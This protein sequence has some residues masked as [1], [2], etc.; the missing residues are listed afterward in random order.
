MT[1]T[2][3]APVP[4]IACVIVS[5]NGAAWIAQCLQSLRDSRDVALQLIVVDNASADETVA[6]VRACADVEMIATGSN[7]GFG[8]ANNLGIARALQLGAELVFILNQD[9]H[10][11]P[12]ALAKLCEQAAAQPD[13]GIVCP[14]QLDAQGQEMDP[15]F[16]R[17]YL[18]PFAPALLN[19][20]VLARPWQ[21]QYRVE[22]VPA[23]AW[24]L[25]RRFLEQ[26][27]GFDPLFFM[28][29][30]DDDL[31]SRARHHG[32]GIALVPAAHFFHCRG[33]HGQLGQESRRGHFRRRRSRLRSALIRQIKHPAGGFAKNCWQALVV[34]GLAGLIALLAHLDWMEALAALA[35]LLTVSC[36]LPRLARHRR[37]CLQGGALWLGAKPVENNS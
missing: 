28:Y 5:Y 33:F 37:Q 11:A 29:C 7:L 27:G 2:A 4:R 32:W 10:V 9:A 25:P 23:A 34:Q 35:A 31:C 26:V 24:L 20:A 19:D 21:A 13:L 18:A 12:D 17:Y 6:I 8:R 36:E 3:L 22:A 1:V 30:E 15:T 14:L 16:L